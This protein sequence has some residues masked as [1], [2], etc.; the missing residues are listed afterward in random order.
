MV[1]AWHH[2]DGRLPYF[3]VQTVAGLATDQDK[4]GEVH[5]YEHDLPTCAQEIAE[6]DVDEDR[7]IL[8][9]SILLTKS[10]EQDDMGK[11]LLFSFGEGVKDDIPIW[12]DKIYREK[13]VLCDGDGPIVIQ[14]KWFSQFYKSPVVS[15]RG[16]GSTATDGSAPSMADVA[17]NSRMATR[18]YPNPRR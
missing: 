18:R 4:W 10:L 17:P 7:T 12:R 3:E 5:Y 9:W 13:P 16:I 8:R 11:T 2:S 14:R 1:L 6:N 15:M